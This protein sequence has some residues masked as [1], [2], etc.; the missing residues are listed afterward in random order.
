MTKINTQRCLV[1]LL[2][3]INTVAVAQKNQFRYRR[4]ID[5]S[6]EGW[7]F[8]SLPADMFRNVGRSF[9]DLRIYKINNNDTLEV[10]YLL[11][12]RNDRITEE[13]IEPSVINKSRK[14]GK[15]FLT[16][17]LKKDQ[18]VNFLDLQFEEENF[19]AFADI[20]GSHD[21]RS[22]F[23]LEKN[24]RMLS[25][26][27]SNVHFSSTTLSFPTANY[28][29]LRVSVS[30][31]KAL[32]F[33]KVS[34]RDRTLAAGTFT[35]AELKWQAREDRPSKSTVVTLNL[36]HE[37][38]VGKFSIDADAH[39]ADFYRHVVF[40]A[41]SDSASTDKGW[42]YYYDRVYEG[43]ITSLQVNEFTLHDPAE[44][45]RFRITI[46]NADS[47][48][49]DVRNVR[50]WATEV[51]LIARLEPGDNYLFYGN[52]AVS[53]PS[54]DLVHFKDKIVTDSTSR[55]LGPEEKM[56]AESQKGSPLFENKLWLW[57]I[58]V[59]V[60][61]VLGFFTVRMMKDR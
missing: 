16:F 28:P 12:V 56:V 43:Y 36:A 40:E 48:P 29:Y 39:G 42:V 27:N 24:Q 10:P 3:L 18:R 34:F 9:S 52:P 49:L 50:A 55:S 46:E 51:R 17:E 15:L 58:M 7:Y 31:D 25:V 41:L 53:F 11:E 54:Y 20:E 38:P 45:G 57:G 13:S 59:L 37:Q 1:A 4:K 47:P 14:D 33:S 26:N 44:A 60:I 19:N 32:T 2:L 8:I 21:Q 22:W 6:G 35:D 61:G 30:S 23:E 5:V